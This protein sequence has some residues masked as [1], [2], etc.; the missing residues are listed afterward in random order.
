[1][2]IT[3]SRLKEIIK[4]ELDLVEASASKKETELV[5]TEATRHE[6]GTALTVKLR[7]NHPHMPE[8]E[9]QK[10]VRDMLETLSYFIDSESIGEP[11]AGA[12]RPRGSTPAH[13]PLEEEINEDN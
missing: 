1:M 12:E 10:I 9:V 5:L 4:E 7:Q 8:K 13:A 6:L 3:K 11:L 2:K